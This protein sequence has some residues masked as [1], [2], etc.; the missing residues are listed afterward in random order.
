M[1]GRQGAGVS[2]LVIAVVALVAALLAASAV[3]RRA[4]RRAAEARERARRRRRRMPV[5]SAN[6]RG[7]PRGDEQDLWTSEGAVGKDRLA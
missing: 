6:V 7:L 1:K 5:V 4:A 2:T 3:K